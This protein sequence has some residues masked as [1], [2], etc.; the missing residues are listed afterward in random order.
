MSSYGLRIEELDQ[1]IDSQD[2][3]FYASGE[4]KIPTLRQT[5]EFAKQA[6]ILINIELKTLPRMYPGLADAVVALIKSME[7]EH[8]VLISSFDHEQLIKIR[9]LTDIIATGVITHDRIA[10][11]S[12][13]L[14]LL[15]ADAYHPCCYGD[16][17]SI[18]FGAVSPSLDPS[19]I[20]NVRQYG[21][22]VNVWTCNNKDEIQQLVA[23]GVTGIISDF[24]NRVRDVLIALN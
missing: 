20:N 8:L 21:Y 23:A 1:F 13:Y 18:G 7:L 15:D 22:G 12:A 3:E 10:S 17:D 6:N 14:K 16:N 19:G 9:R 2:R 11:P 5:L 24:P 4:I